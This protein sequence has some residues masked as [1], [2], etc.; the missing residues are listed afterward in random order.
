VF[1][2]DL[3]V[4]LIEDVPVERYL[5]DRAASASTRSNVEMAGPLFR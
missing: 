5:L 2:T 4:E 1:E 3:D